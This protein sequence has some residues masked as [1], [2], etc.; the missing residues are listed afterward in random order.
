MTDIKPGDIVFVDDVRCVAEKARASKDGSLRI[1]ANGCLFELKHGN[2]NECVDVNKATRRK[3]LRAAWQYE[4]DTKIAEARS[5]IN[6]R[7]YERASLSLITNLLEVLLKIEM[8]D[9]ARIA[10]L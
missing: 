9:A 6:N 2:W 5:L 3:R 4:L 7:S 1:K 8:E 10:A